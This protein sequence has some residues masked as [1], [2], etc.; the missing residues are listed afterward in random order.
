MDTEAR[1]TE[2]YMKGGFGKLGSKIAYKR[3]AKYVDQLNGVKPIDPR[4][5]I[6]YIFVPKTTPDPK[7]NKEDM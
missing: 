6:G 4:E 1:A 2:R 5:W 3:Y 7:L